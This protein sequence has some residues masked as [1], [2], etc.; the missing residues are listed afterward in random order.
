MFKKQNEIY[1]NHFTNKGSY[2]MHLDYFNTCKYIRIRNNCNI[3]LID[4]LF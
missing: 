2:Y 1:L 3:R 4:M